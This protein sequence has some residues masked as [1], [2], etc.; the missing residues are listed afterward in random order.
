M[1]R[2]LGEG[3]DSQART[4]GSRQERHDYALLPQQ[5]P[6]AEQW[7]LGLLQRPVR[8]YPPRQLS[9]E[10]LKSVVSRSPSVRRMGRLIQFRFRH[11]VATSGTEAVLVSIHPATEP[12]IMSLNVPLS[13]LASPPPPSWARRSPPSRPRPTPPPTST[14]APAPA[15]ATAG[16]TCCAAATAS[17]LTTA[18]AAGAS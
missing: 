4:A 12:S 10:A 1:P 6:V 13:P 18:A 17:T 14:S 7:R 11:G 16:S 5:Q 3:Q 9:R 8:L 2:Q 15:P